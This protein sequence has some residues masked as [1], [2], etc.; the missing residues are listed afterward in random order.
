MLYKVVGLKHK[1]LKFENR[2]VL[3]YSMS[4]LS[5]PSHYADGEGE[6]AET[7]FVSDQKMCSPSP[8]IGQNIRIEWNRWGK[9]ESVSVAK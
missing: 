8:A 7:F 3:G 2:D 9:V 1:N 6:L 4:V 5:R